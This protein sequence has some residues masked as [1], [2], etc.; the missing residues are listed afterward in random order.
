MKGIYIFLF[1]AGLCAGGVAGYRMKQDAPPTQTRQ[2][3]YYQD[4]MH[5]AYRSQKPGT[6][7]DCGMDLVP[8]YADEA[9]AAARV[10]NAITISA[11]RQRQFGIQTVPASVDAGTTSI[12]L[13]ARVQADETRVFK[14]DFGTDGYV[15]ETHDD[16]AG[17]RVTKNQRLATVYSPEILSVA[18]GYLSANERASGSSSMTKEAASSAAQGAAT[19]G[20]RADRLRNLGMSDA[21]IEEISQTRKLPEDAYVVSP[22]DGFILSRNVAPGMRFERHMEL[23]RVADISR[24][25]VEA[26]AFGQQAEAV[27]VGQKG[28]VLIPGSTHSMDGVVVGVLPEVDPNTRAVKIRLRVDN[29]G[30]KLRP[31]EFVTAELTTSVPRGVTVPV[32]AVIDSGSTQR[33]FVRADDSHFVP[34][35]VRTGAQIGDRIQVV[36]GL[37]AGEA[38]VLSST[39]LVDS[40]ARLRSPESSR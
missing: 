15:K 29:P 2:I 14:L 12:R 10:D 36:S 28:R 32:D 6:A 25:W 19:A 20:A 1:A 5:P 27:Q 40:E 39:F 31:G 22:V 35:V 33:V 18:G 9:G 11:A 30:F 16:A 3:L 7:P 37:E 38:V 17:S 21:Q 23:Y 26:E 34:R 13:F 4:P 24:V 8:V